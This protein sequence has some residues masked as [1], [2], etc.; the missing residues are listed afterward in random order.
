MLYT[1]AVTITTTNLTEVF[2]VPSGFMAH[3]NYIF[4]ENHSLNDVDMDLYIREHHNDGTHTDV[5][6]M[7]S[8]ELKTAEPKEFY[9]GT[10]V[11]HGGDFL[12]AQ[13][14]NAEDN[15]VV[16]ATFDLFEE[17]AVLNNFSSG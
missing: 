3:L 5:Y 13:L 10:F 17:P 9:N 6:L 14:D 16:V 11:M 1:K 12:K 7:D 2:T 8:T 4:L 15:I